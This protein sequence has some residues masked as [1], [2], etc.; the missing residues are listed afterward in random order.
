MFD[1][2]NVKDRQERTQKKDESFG[3]RKEEK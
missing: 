2:N 3:K 1:D